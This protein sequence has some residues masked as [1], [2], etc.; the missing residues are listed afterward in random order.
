MTE[1]ED[2]FYHRPHPGSCHGSC[3]CPN[4]KGTDLTFITPDADRLWF[5]MDYPPSIVEKC[6]KKRKLIKN[7]CTKTPG[8]DGDLVQ[9]G[10]KS[11]NYYD[12]QKCGKFQV[13]E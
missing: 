3:K 11:Y 4:L 9:R 12:C 1:C 2:C 8:C 5:K 6:K 10:R 7:G 13:I